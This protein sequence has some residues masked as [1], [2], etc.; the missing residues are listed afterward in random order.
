MSSKNT[1]LA[2]DGSGNRGLPVSEQV[3]AKA[4]T[5][6]VP[7]GGGV[8]FF[9]GGGVSGGGGGGFFCVFFFGGGGGLRRGGGDRD[10]FPSVCS[11][12][13]GY[14]EVALKGG[15][16]RHRGSNLNRNPVAPIRVNPD[17]QPASKR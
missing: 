16:R 10:L 7:L 5:G 15:S 8:F 3:R 1:S 6:W 2:R 14:G 12:R 11:L 4:L 9:W 17:V 13:D